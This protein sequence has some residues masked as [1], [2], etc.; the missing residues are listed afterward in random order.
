MKPGLRAKIANKARRHLIRAQE[1]EAKAPV[2][3][4][5]D[6]GPSGGN[7]GPDKAEIEEEVEEEVREEKE[8]EVQLEELGDKLDELA[9]TNEVIV[10]SLEDIKKVIEKGVDDS[11]MEEELDEAQEE[12]S[13]DFTAEEFGI[14][15]DNLVV[16][17][18]DPMSVKSKLRA[19]RKARLY[20]KSESMTPFKDLGDS[21]SYDKAKSKKY[22]STIPSAPNTKVKADP[23][24][25]MFKIANIELELG[26]DKRNWIVLQKKAGKEIPFCIV[27]VKNPIQATRSFGI[28]LLRQMK[29]RG[30][31]NTLK[32]YNAKRIVVKKKAHK[33]ASGKDHHRRFVRA[34]KLALTAMNKNLVSN[35]LKASMLEVLDNFG[36]EA[37]DAIT[38]IE[39]T[40]H[41]ASMDHFD[42]ALN[43]TAKYLAK[44]DEAFVEIE[45]AIGEMNTD[46][47]KVASSGSKL[48]Q[49]AQDLRR[50]ASHNSLNISTASDY[51]P[52]EAES[53]AQRIQRALPKPRLSHVGQYVKKM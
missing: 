45:A 3:E 8:E 48:S 6:E 19:A 35:P 1:E 43:E 13:E 36:I 29:A 46:V 17:K 27:P 49:K 32:K 23:A 16:S 50:Q 21:F 39:G 22:K 26:R 42:V 24:P 20:K 14:N 37:S 12:E 40:F 31:V 33:T 5:G 11:G 28:N 41:K 52:N 18:E 4:I 34:F 44:S 51:T 9:D 47:P 30:V 53:L 7:E 25:D 15:P 2:P 10:D 38:A